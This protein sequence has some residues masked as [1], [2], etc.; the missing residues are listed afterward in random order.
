MAFIRTTAPAAAKE[1]VLEMY[2]HQ[3]AAW[4]FVP[5]YAKIFSGRPEVLA[6]WGRLLAEIRRPMSKRR[7]ELVT[8]AAA[9]ELRNTACSLAHGKALTEFFTAEEVCAMKEDEFSD[10]VTEAERAVFRFARQVAK[11]ASRITSGAVDLL[12]KHGL[13]D[14]EIF[15]VVATAA[16]RAFF[17]KLLD[18]LGVESDSSFL[19][20]D[21]SFRQAMTV[22][23]P[24]SYRAVETV[25]TADPGDDYRPGSMPAKRALHE[26]SVSAMRAHSRSDSPADR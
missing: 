15:D 23:R 8:F 2:K 13:N 22:G 19:E 10:S 14:D 21:A 20:L 16:G 5:N 4:G 18:A 7:F 6:R 12:R 11:D 24:I 9:L 17:T 3:Q 1:Q 25:E 26:N